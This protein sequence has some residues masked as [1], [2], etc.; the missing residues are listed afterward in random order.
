MVSLI[1]FRNLEYTTYVAGALAWDSSLK[2]KT[3]VDIV[4]KYLSTLQN[5]I[6]VI[7]EISKT[8]S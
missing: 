2:N 4:I 6:V 1:Q 3:D 7:L 5:V 8:L